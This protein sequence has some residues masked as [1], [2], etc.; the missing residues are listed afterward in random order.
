MRYLTYKPEGYQGSIDF[1]L[2]QIVKELH[3]LL[4]K[5]HRSILRDYLHLK[6]E[7]IQELAGIL[8]DFTTDIHCDIGIWKCYERY[9]IKFFRNPLPLTNHNF[10]KPL[11]D[12]HLDRVRHLL[13][14]LCREFSDVVFSPWDK[15]IQ[16]LT[17]TVQRFL[18]DRYASL[19]QDSGVK[20]FLETSNDYGWDIKRKL[21]WLGSKSYLFRVFF[22]QYMLEECGGETQI[23]YTDDFVC[24][25]C[26]PWSGLGVIDILAGVLY[27]DDDN[28]RKD[29]RSWYERHAAPYKI[30][31]ANSKVLKVLNTINNQEYLVRINMKKP[32]FH[33][34]APGYWQ[35]DAVERKMV[36][37][38]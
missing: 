17:E 20:S 31:S 18:N 33:R 15:D 16:D 34:W 27:L 6:N 1:Y 5:T 8:V 38:G 3:Q 35:F 2:P 13:W 25:Q 30:L 12:I 19:P 37:V 14:V 4:S 9:N 32:P 11:N 10:V 22:H 21:V 24:Q 36:L 7:T 26:T 28:D 23:G 29:L